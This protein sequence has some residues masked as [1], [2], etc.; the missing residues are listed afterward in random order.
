LLCF[1]EQHS[2]LHA[3]SGE[4]QNTA[5]G[6][7]ISLSHSPNFTLARQSATRCQTNSGNSDSFDGLKRFLKRTGG[8][9]TRRAII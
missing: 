4:R 8:F 6:G 2:D 5:H 1:N 7:Y 3:I 9:L